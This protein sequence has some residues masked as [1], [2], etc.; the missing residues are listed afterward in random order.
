MKPDKNYISFTG[1]AE[2]NIWR[3]GE[4][5]FCPLKGAQRV[6]VEETSIDLPDSSYADTLK[7][8]GVRNLT[9]IVRGYVKGGYEDCID[10]NNECSN[11]IIKIEGALYPQGNY[12]ITCKG[13]SHDIYIEAHSIASNPKVVDLDLGNISDQSTKTTR[14]IT[15]VLMVGAVSYRQLNA[16]EPFIRPYGK[17]KFS[18]WK[19]LRKP[20]AHYATVRKWIISRA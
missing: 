10:V 19:I 13:G 16:E 7:F 17:C 5:L 15:V 1:D 9:V 12:A 18:L 20:F 8:S 14:R 2:G 3:N 6:W 4:I 11:L